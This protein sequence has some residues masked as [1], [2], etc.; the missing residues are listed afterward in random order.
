MP[1]RE[2][3]ALVSTSIGEVLSKRERPTVRVPVTTMSLCVG[4]L[5]RCGR[6]GLGR[7]LRCGDLDMG[8]GNGGDG[9]RQ[10]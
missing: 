9:K 5:G 4:C 1:W 6:I 3:V 2:R 10:H 7:V 8:E